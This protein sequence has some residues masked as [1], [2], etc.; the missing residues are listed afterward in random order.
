[1]AIA[2]HAV[3][4]AWRAAGATAA[5]ENEGLSDGRGDAVD[6]AGGSGCGAL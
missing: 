5:H 1:M 6:R 4:Q 3:G 2:R